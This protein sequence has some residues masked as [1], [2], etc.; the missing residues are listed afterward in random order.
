MAS[1][2]VRTSAGTSPNSSIFLRPRGDG[3]SDGVIASQRV[4]AIERVAKRC[5]DVS[6]AVMALLTLAPL[7]LILGLLVRCSDGGPALFRQTRIGMGG[8][9]FAC[10]KFRSMTID[11][12]R[13][14]AD[15]LASDPEASREWTDTQK[16]RRDPRI[17]PLGQFL[18][19]TS[20]DELPQIINVLAGEMSLVGPRPIVP[21]ECDRYG[22]NLQHYLSV[23]PGITGLWQVSGRS[24][25]S[26][27]ERVALDVAYARQWRLAT[28]VAI[29]VRTV[30]AVLSQ[31]GSC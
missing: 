16:L 25:S 21:S 9:R 15:H 28:D 24:S 27:A 14:L 10:I 4:V 29:V 5:I 3:H 7:M 12:D 23:R 11:A 1:E 31:R 30:P 13:A 22:D 26:Y 6:A 17:T 18:R 2:S 8:R 19:K 20:L